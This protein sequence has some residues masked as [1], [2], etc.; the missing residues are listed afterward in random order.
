MLLSLERNSVSLHIA[1]MLGISSPVG[2]SAPVLRKL[3]WRWAFGPRIFWVLSLACFPVPCLFWLAAH[4]TVMKGES[5]QGLGFCTWGAEFKREDGHQ[6][7]R[8]YIW[9][10]FTSLSFEYWGLV[11]SPSPLIWRT[12]P[13]KKKVEMF[14]GGYL[15]WEMCEMLRR[16]RMTHVSYCDTSNS[17]I[18]ELLKCVG[19]ELSNGGQ[20]PWRSCLRVF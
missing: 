1:S 15:K 8:T 14:F 16:R 7:T 3:E 9:L 5:Q 10:V 18:T 12:E 20:R 19:I 6:P 17:Y 4:H 13:L 2:S 11:F